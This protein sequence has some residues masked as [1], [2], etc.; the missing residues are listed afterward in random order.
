MNTLPLKARLHK[1]FLSQQLDAIFVALKLQLLARVNQ[2]RFCR[3]DIAGV[4]NM[5]ETWCNFGATK[6]VSSCRDKNRLCKRALIE[7]LESVF[8]R[9]KMTKRLFDCPDQNDVSW[10]SVHSFTVNRDGE[11]AFKYTKK[12]K[13]EDLLAFM[14]E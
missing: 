10:Y 2:V 3:R 4:S 6:I 1:R 9:Q 12:R 8:S 13:A 14:K 7:G 5:F 11:F